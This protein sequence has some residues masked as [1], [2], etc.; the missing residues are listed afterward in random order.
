MDAEQ[1]A[2][3]PVFVPAEEATLDRLRKLEA[4]VESLQRPGLMGSPP[5][6]TPLIQPP[7]PLVVLNA[8]A[9]SAR[10]RWLDWPVIREFRF[11]AFM[12]LDPR[13]RLSR[14]G[15]FGVPAVFLAALV[16]YLILN[17]LIVNI[18][19]LTQFTERVI[20]LGLGM[21]LFLL[22]RREAARYRVVLDYLAG[23]SL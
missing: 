14:V 9:N 6:F 17:Y 4:L 18:P 8:A 2:S 7:A 21:V 5:G 16:N 10:R 11:I 12:Y 1:P 13:Y 15:Q 23:R 3:P 20:L 22:L 19:F